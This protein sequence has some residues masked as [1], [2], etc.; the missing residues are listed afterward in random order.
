MT[1]WRCFTKPFHRGGLALRIGFASQSQSFVTDWLCFSKPLHCDGLA[2]LRKA[3]PLS[4]QELAL[5]RKA[6]PSWI[7]FASQSQSKLKKNVEFISKRLY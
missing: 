7:G 5:L 1:N 4:E 3:N 6:F 2:L